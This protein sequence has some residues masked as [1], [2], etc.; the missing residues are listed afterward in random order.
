MQY[1]NKKQ[2]IGNIIFLIYIILFCNSFCAATNINITGD[3]ASSPCTVSDETRSLTVDL[4]K[5]SRE[6]IN[7]AGGGGWTPF[8]LT[9][10]HCPVSM[11]NVIVT[12]SGD[13]EAGDNKHFRN[14]GDASGVA[15]EIADATHNVVYGNADSA[16]TAIDASQNAQ[17]SLSARAISPQKNATAGSF[18]SVVLITFNYE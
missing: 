12:F 3:I 17:F 13:S 4:G 2:T 16:T 6:E 9:L 1:V 14:D 8:K 5:M 11:S 15:L 7:R 18:N 10:S